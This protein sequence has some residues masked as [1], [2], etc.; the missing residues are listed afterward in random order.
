MQSVVYPELTPDIRNA[1]VFS[2]PLAPAILD[3]AEKRAGGTQDAGG[4]TGGDGKN[5]HNVRSCHSTFTVE[6][7]GVCHGL[8]GYFETILYQPEDED[9]VPIELSTNPLTMD[10]K[11]K[12]MIS[13]FPIFFPLQRPLHVPDGGQI[14]VWM[15]RQTD[16][17]KVWYEWSVEVYMKETGKRRHKLGDSGLHS[18]RKNGC[19]M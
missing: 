10:A 3:H 8:A 14:E 7:R 15:W 12:D 19:L 1:W 6:H 16:D 9:A 4:F 11:S 2:H 13:W 5:E 18:S 17:R